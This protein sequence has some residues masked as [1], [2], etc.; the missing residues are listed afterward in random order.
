MRRLCVA[1]CVLIPM[2]SAARIWAKPLL[3][4]G[5]KDGE[6]PTL[7]AVLTDR[8]GYEV[9][10]LA[11]A[12]V[13]RRLGGYDAVVMYVHRPIRL[14]IE[15]A[16]I[17]YT[18]GGGRLLVLHHGIA[19][20]KWQNPEWLS[21]VGVSMA[22]RDDPERPWGVEANT[23]YTLVNLAPGHYVTS[24]MIR[25]DCEVDYLSPDSGTRRGRYLALDL[26]DTEV[27]RNQCFTDGD[28]K[29]VLFGYRHVDRENGYTRMEDT[30][31][32]MKPA[33]KGWLF[34]LQP[35]HAEHDFSHSHFARIIL[36]CL[37]WQ[38]GKQAEI[39]DS[40]LKNVER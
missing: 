12:G 39:V 16:L 34:Y 37:D 6:L 13:D 21:F 29:T 8:G 10:A 27:F 31:G 33:G 7:A 25:Y 32:W 30:A 28:V 3:I 24:H 2:G 40:R 1:M 19:S 9:Q 5:D 14:H 23:T 35:G 11:Q 22:P 38:P 17:D 15:K 18:N 4:I 26:P 20:A 36:N